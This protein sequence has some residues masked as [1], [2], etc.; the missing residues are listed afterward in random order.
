VAE[1]AADPKRQ[2]RADADDSYDEPPNQGQA[3]TH[4][5]GSPRTKQGHVADVTAS[6]R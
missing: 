5:V 4:G 2:N 1:D 6:E 3:T